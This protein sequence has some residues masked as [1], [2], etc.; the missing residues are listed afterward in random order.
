VQGRDDLKIGTCSGVMLKWILNI[1][2]MSLS[3]NFWGGGGAQTRI[4][5]RTP[6]NTVKNI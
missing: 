5:L 6:V 2:D 3:T 4:Q 1:Q